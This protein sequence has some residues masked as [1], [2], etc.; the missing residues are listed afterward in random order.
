MIFCSIHKIDHS[1]GA[2]AAI[3][4]E[5]SILYF[6]SGFLGR[7]KQFLCNFLSVISVEVNQQYM[8]NERMKM[9]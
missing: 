3:K 4:R 5:I 9:K 2:M 1:P 6:P 7:V 8:E